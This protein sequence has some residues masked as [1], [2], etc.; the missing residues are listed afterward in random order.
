MPK[1]GRKTRQK[2]MDAA[3]TL[4]LEQGFSATSVDRIIELADI[5]KGSFFY[6]FKTKADLAQA[7]VERF[8]EFDNGLLTSKMQAAEAAGTDPARQLVAFV[9]G[10]VEIFES[11]KGP[12]PGCLFASFCYESGLMEERTLAVSRE[13]IL[14]WRAFLGAKIEQ[15]V[16]ARPPRIAV[17]VAG[18]AD[19][20]TVVFEGAYVV[21]RSL[22]DND[23][24]LRQLA[25]YR[26]YLVLLF[27]LDREGDCATAG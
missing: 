14:T 6:H 15:A 5:T 4:I 7:L 24:M 21:A 27:G 18:L 11:L 2:I 8:A 20:I 9:D 16:A 19:M 23:V 3:E 25:H 12:N 1:D 22:G 26:N 10:F 17:D 13:T